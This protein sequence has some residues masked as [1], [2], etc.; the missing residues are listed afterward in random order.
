MGQERWSIRSCG[1]EHNRLNVVGMKSMCRGGGL[2]VLENNKNKCRNTEIAGHEGA[3]DSFA[4]GWMIFER[5]MLY[6]GNKAC[7]MVVGHEMHYSSY[8]CM[9]N[10][11]RCIKWNCNVQ[12]LVFKCFIRG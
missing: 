10:L 8:G 9:V 4:V 2:I 11:V 5:S 3:L 7:Y 1:I 12:M 6:D